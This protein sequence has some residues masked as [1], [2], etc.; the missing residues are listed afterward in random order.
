MGAT[1]LRRSK[2]QKKNNLGFHQRA[3]SRFVSRAAT[4]IISIQS[5]LHHD[6]IMQKAG[7]ARSAKVIPRSHTS[8]TPQ[9]Q[10]SAYTLALRGLSRRLSPEHIK[11]LSYRCWLCS[12]EQTRLVPHEQDNFKRISKKVGKDQNLTKNG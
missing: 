10:D 8:S 9:S 12:Y 1:C 2:Q 5:Q 3:H 4:D 7:N 11:K 6:T